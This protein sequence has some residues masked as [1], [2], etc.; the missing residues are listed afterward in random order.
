MV[1]TIAPAIP[2]QTWP[3]IKGGQYLEF[4]ATANNFYTFTFCIGGGAAT[5][6]TQLTILDS[7]GNYANGFADDDCFLGSYLPYWSPPSSGTYRILTSSYP[8]TNGLNCGTLAYK[9]EPTPSNIAGGVSAAAPFSIGSLPFSARGLS[10]CQFGNEYNS[11]MACGSNYLNGDDFVFSYNGTAGECLNVYTSETFTYTGLFLF[12]GDPANPATNC[13]AFREGSAGSPFLS[14]VSLPATQTYYIVVS[15]SPGPPCTPFDIEIF[16]CPATPGQGNTCATAISVPS[17]PFIQNGY[18][19]CGFGNDYN[20]AQACNNFYMNGEDI[21]FRYTSPGNECIQIKVTN[22]QLYTGFFVMDGCPDNPA[23]NCIASRTETG[24][25]PILRRIELGDPGDYYIVVASNP[26]TPCTQFD[27]AIDICPPLCSR[28]SNGSDTCFTP[29]AVTLGPGD[30]I[31]GFTNLDHTPDVGANLSNVFCGS[32]ENNSWFTFVA[33]SAEMS[34]GINTGS[35]LTGFGLQAQVFSTT[36]CFN[37]TPVSLCWNPMVPTDGYIRATGLTI[38]NTYHL[39]VDGY[40]GDDCEYNIFRVQGPLP[41]EFGTLTA[42][43]KDKEVTLFWETLSEINNNGFVIERGQEDFQLEPG[44]IAWKD[45]GTVESPGDSDAARSYS[46]VDEVEFNGQPYFYRLRQVDIDGK[47]SYSST[48][49]VEIEGPSSSQ[50][51]AVYPNPASDRVLLR[52]YTQDAAQVSLELYNLTGQRVFASQNSAARD[53]VFE[54][55]WNLEDV[56]NGL[57]VYRVLIGSE[58]FQGKLEIKR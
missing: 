37:F 44:H 38:G 52:Y 29:T 2:W 11:T 14:N 32:I 16:N 55:E 42:E 51:M 33:D 39:M 18:T 41:V 46:Y 10:T 6:D 20:S 49:R 22:T 43:A 31:C 7:A 24:G 5:W 13:V 21:V 45:V 58:S 56:A 28:N 36:N 48:V 17:L 35:C 40:A 53:R 27:L 25:N 12:D 57:Y 54:E 1:G 8:C 19:T 4:Y 9:C 50:L 15:T 23:T 3:C 47:S 30:T 26:T 34:F